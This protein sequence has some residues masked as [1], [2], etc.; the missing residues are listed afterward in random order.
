MDL[1][2][3][4]S[5]PNVTTKDPLSPSFNPSKVIFLVVTLPSLG[6]LLL[7]TKLILNASFSL[8]PILIKSLPPNIFLK[9]EINML[10]VAIPPMDLHLVV[11]MTFM[12]P[13]NA[14]KTIIAALTFLVVILIPLEKGMEHLL[15]LIISLY[16]KLKCIL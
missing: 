2:H 15:V 7:H 5:M 13:T 11:V 4:N 3:L 12:F 8:S 6:T 1:K 16:V 14:I 9:M 10:F